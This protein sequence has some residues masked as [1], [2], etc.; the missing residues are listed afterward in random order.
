MLWS[1]VIA[2]NIAVTIAESIVKVKANRGTEVGV[3][4]SNYCIRG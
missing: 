4:C 3:Y 1:T 2:E